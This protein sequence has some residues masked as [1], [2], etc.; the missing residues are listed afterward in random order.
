MKIKTI[1]LEISGMTC[2]GCAAGVAKKLERE[3]IIDREVSYPKASAR[4]SFDAEKISSQEIS[5]LVN[6]TGH[7]K[8]TGSEEIESSGNE[9]RHLI[10]IGGGSAAFAA[11]LE[12]R[13]HRARVT[14]INDGLP[15]GGTCVNVGCVPSKN[16]IRAAE[17]VHKAQNIPFAGISGSAEVSDF[18]ALMNQKRELVENLRQQKYINVV[19]D[20]ENFRLIRGRATVI[21]PTA[22]EVN[23]ETIHGSHILIATGARP[24]IPDIPGLG[25]VPWLTSQDALELES[26][27]ESVIILGGRYIALELAQMFRRLGSRVTLLQRSERIMPAESPELTAALTRYLE[28]E[29]LRIVTGNQLQKVR[30]R[31]GRIVV[32]SLVNGAAGTFEAETLIV[33]TGRL[34]NS[35]GMGLASVGVELKANGAVETDGHLQTAVPTI[36]AAGDVLGKNMFVYTAA[37]EGKLAVHNMFS[38][39]K[40][41]ADY[42]ALGWVVFT[43]PQIAGVGMD[44]RQARAAGIEAESAT[45]PL[46]HVPRALAARDTRGFIQLIREKKSDKLIGARILAPEGSELIMEA[47]MAIRFGITTRRIREMFHPYLT[48]GEGMKLA[49]ITFDKNVEALSCCAT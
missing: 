5:D 38:P 49:A 36:F 11:A 3:G 25:K 22:V 13:E 32:E 15:V 27:P 37:Y 8:V 39:V 33:A 24:H 28:D 26:L 16:L 23:G 4:V 46:S 12:A 19:K 17:S 10:I 29:G 47:A 14:M 35:D 18:R 41:T 48:L 40:R 43:D 31:K 7:Y 6:D 20:M 2:D 34:P 45:L 44:E 9:D 42:S 30:Q 1:L 21:S